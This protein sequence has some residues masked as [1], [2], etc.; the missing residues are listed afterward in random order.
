[1]GPAS[2]KYAKSK[3][4]NRLI[5]PAN[6]EDSL[7]FF[8][9]AF[10]RCDRLV[11]KTGLLLSPAPTRPGCAPRPPATPTPGVREWGVPMAS[12]SSRDP[13]SR[14]TRCRFWQYLG[15]ALAA[16][17]GEDRGLGAPAGEGVRSWTSPPVGP[18]QH[19]S[20]G[21]PRL[22]RAASRLP[23]AMTRSLRLKRNTSW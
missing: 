12:R 13:I 14:A 21:P 1:M 7:R 11:G 17:P 22:S 9:F 19:S 18:P 10:C 20:R 2:N 23:G 15:P 4:F 5:S 6:S 3:A 8:G 16:K